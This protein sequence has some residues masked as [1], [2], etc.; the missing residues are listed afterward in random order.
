MT[1]GL[2]HGFLTESVDTAWGTFAAGLPVRIL[3]TDRGR[4]HVLL[5]QVAATRF[6][7]WLAT[8]S[9]GSQP[10]SRSLPD[11]CRHPSNTARPHRPVRRDNDSGEDAVRQ[12]PPRRRT[13][14]PMVAAPR[15]GLDGWTCPQ[16]RAAHAAYLHGVRS[17]RVAAGERLYQRELARQNRRKRQ[18]LAS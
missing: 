10:P 11:R 8:D 5:G 15:I 14:V 13:P 9:V 16:L 2:T 12:P 3:D 18:A 1:D 7:E 4:V 6:T 17:P